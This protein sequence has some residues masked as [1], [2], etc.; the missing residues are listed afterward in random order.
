MSRIP[1]ISNSLDKISEIDGLVYLDIGENMSSEPNINS[2]VLVDSAQTN[3]TIEDKFYEK[4][5]IK[6]SNSGWGIKSRPMGR[7][8]VLG[9]LVIGYFAYKK[10]NK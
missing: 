2:S 6:Y 4:L 10:F 7:L 5:G 3:M 1:I 8:L 9:A